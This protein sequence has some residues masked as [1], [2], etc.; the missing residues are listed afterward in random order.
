MSENRAYEVL[1]SITEFGRNRWLIK[2]PFCGSTVW[3][4]TW[5]LAGSGKRCPGCGAKHT[6]EHGTVRREGK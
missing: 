6:W 1:D 5:S 4:Y 3:A 2:C